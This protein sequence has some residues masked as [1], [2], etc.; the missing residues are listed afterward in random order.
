MKRLHVLTMTALLA[1]A[2]CGES[3]DSSHG[4]G[5]AAESAPSAME[6]S[7]AEMSGEALFG[8]HCARCHNPGDAGVYPGTQQLS[9]TRGEEKAVLLERDD[10]TPAYVRQVVRHGI[11]AMATFRPSEISASELDALAVY[12]AGA[13]EK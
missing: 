5:A 8:T 6:A 2:G 4:E 3:S 1:L 11:G 13:T 7:L 12:V 9:L 10:I